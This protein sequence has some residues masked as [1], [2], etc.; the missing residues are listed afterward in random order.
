MECDI[1]GRGADSTNPLHCITC[2]RS[3]LEHP[4]IELAKT[5]IDRDAVEKHV[6][7]IIQGS[8]DKA[9]QH[10]SL[11]DSKGGLLVDRQEC[12]NNLNWQRTKAETAEIQ[13]RLQSIS[14]HA[15]RLREQMEATRKQLEAK[16]A[17]NSQRKSDLSSATY[18]IDSRRANE[19]DKVQQK[20]KKVDYNADKM[21]HDTIDLRM[22]L[23]STAAKL[24]GLKLDRSKSRGG[25]VKDVF[26]IGAG[27][28]LRVYD[29]RD[30]NGTVAEMSH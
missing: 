4:R 26:S 9:I 10:V 14:E 25:S 3:Y 28:P 22:Q 5:L 8:E 1:C 13:E 23:C 19:L 18:G 17:A 30:L 11:A 24:A 20:V 7:A 29:L 2:A 15:D 16:R 21:H 6:K 27:K 12:T